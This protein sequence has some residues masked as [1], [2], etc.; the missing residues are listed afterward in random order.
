MA[1][2]SAPRPGGVDGLN[3]DD[4]GVALLA[5]AV[6]GVDRERMVLVCSGEL[7]GV[8]RPGPRLILDA[9]EARYAG[10]GAVP[11]AQ[12]A[13]LDPSFEVAIVWPRAHLGKDFTQQCIAIAGQVLGE[14]G[15]L[16]CAVKKQKGADSIADFMGEVFGNVRV[17]ERAKG[18]RLLCSERVQPV[19]RHEVLDRRYEITDARLGELA[20]TSAPGAFSRKGLDVGTQCLIDHVARLDLNPARVV[21]LGA[22]V[23]PIALWAAKQWPACSVVAVESNSVSAAMLRE[24]VQTAG[25]HGRVFP[26]EH[27]GLPSTVA[28]VRP[29]VGT[30]EVTLTNPPTHADARALDELLGPLASWQAKG[31]KTFAVVNRP[32]M[33]AGALRRAGAQV[34]AVEYERFFVLEATW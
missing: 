23:G 28:A 32:D 19:A 6:A 17:L 34:V 14:G 33:V 25:F 13:S 21:D 31:S 15:R 9:R 16:L 1:K 18:Y 11:F 4:P 8:D 7:P 3:A 12:W 2:R 24:N 10:A 20:L 22:G 5:E 30:T 26:M 27:N 29:F